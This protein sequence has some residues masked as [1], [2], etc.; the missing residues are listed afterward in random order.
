MVD[1]VL[2][3]HHRLPSLE[4]SEHVRDLRERVDN[5]KHTS[6]GV[7]VD[8]LVHVR[9]GQDSV[10]LGDEAWEV[11]PAPKDEQK[12]ADERA[13]RREG[14]PAEQVAQLDA[15]L[16]WVFVGDQDEHDVAKSRETEL[17][18]AEQERPATKTWSL[19]V[20][21][22]QEVDRTELEDHTGHDVHQP[23]VRVQD[24]TRRGAAV[25]ADGVNEVHVR[26][27]HEEHATDHE[28][29][30]SKEPAFAVPQDRVLWVKVDRAQ[31]EEHGAEEVGENLGDLEHLHAGAQRSHDGGR[32]LSVGS[33]LL[34]VAW[35]QMTSDHVACL[36]VADVLGCV[37]CAVDRE[38]CRMRLRGWVLCGTASLT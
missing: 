20:P 6:N 29:P 28:C 8:R 27:E 36:L 3:D 2:G 12:G 21:V 1:A 9:L 25:V 18:A 11:E 10:F 13:Q 35:G 16:L 23:I 26:A 32:V 4:A 38:N 37:R 30:T 34:G 33:G 19:G 7:K 14:S 17:D 5:E 24:L 15:R 22:W 31:L